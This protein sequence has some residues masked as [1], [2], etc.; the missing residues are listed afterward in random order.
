MLKSHVK[1]ICLKLSNFDNALTYLI[2]DF[3]SSKPYVYGIIKFE[4]HSLNKSIPSLI[5]TVIYLHNLSRYPKR[6]FS[7]GW[8]TI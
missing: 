2:I 7:I 5:S 4:W 8:F 3:Y 6:F 1:Q